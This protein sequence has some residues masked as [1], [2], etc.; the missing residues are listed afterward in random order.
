MTNL[1]QTAAENALVIANVKA[2]VSVTPKCI[3]F[4]EMATK[5]DAEKLEKAFLEVGMVSLGICNLEEI[6]MGIGWSLTVSY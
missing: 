2:V 1:I 5:K 6:Q 4:D 3:T